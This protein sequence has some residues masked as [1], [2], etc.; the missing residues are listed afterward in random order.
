MKPVRATPEQR[1]RTG[2]PTGRLV[3][4]RHGRTAWNSE[5]RCQ[6]W[7]DV[8][9]DAL[10]EAQ[11]ECLAKRL[12]NVDVRR[13]VASDLLRT[14]QTAEAITS[15]H[16]LEVSIDVDLREFNF[17]DVQGEVLAAIKDTPLGL[18]WLGWKRGLSD[19][20]LPGG[21]GL[22]EVAQRIGPR[23]RTELERLDGGATVIVGHGSSMRVGMCAALGLDPIWWRSL[24]VTNGSVSELEVYG[25]V[26]R[27][28]RL[29]DTCHLDGLAD[30]SG[31]DDAGC[32]RDWVL[33]P[34]ETG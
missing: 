15:T 22:A 27:L 9:L 16:G 21:E 5:G 4:V 25:G 31:S 14:R 2:G 20:A 8:P 34:E 33:L 19:E 11:A 12:S 26:A 10:G 30:R 7:L 24:V 23:L 1:E 32:V 6:G 17:G 18:R 13:V 28:A 29:N 3:F